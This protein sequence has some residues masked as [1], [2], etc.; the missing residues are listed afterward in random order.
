MN[1]LFKTP[2]FIQALVLGFIFLTP[3][4]ILEVVNRWKFNEGFPFAVFA[5]MWV[6]QTLFMLILIPI[7]RTARTEKISTSIPATLVLR[8]VGLLLL[9]Y[10]WGGW[11][12]DQW[13]CL[14]GIPN[15][16]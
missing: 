9:A 2:L 11:I 14:M 5:F 8:I 1:K 7:V 12:V 6:L 10:I 3:F 4:V 15:C 16:D 13:P